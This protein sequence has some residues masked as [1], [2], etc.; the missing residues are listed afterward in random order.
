MK[1]ITYQ[2][3]LV[4][5]HGTAV[6]RASDGLVV[7]SVSTDT[8]T[9]TQGA[10]FVALQGDNFD[11]NLYGKTAAERGAACLL[12]SSVTDDVAALNIPVI[13][14][15]DT[16]LALQR[17]AMW[18]RKQLDVEVIGITGSNGKTS[19]KDF[20]ASVL[21]ERFKVNATKGN[22][23]NHIGLPLS[24]LSTEAD[25][26]V[27]VWEMG[28]NHAGEIAPL[29]EISAPNIGIIT[30]IGTAH[31]EHLGSREGIAEEKA[32]LARSLPEQGTLILPA[33]CDFVDY[34][35]ERTRA[36]VLIAG[37]CRG[38]VRAE[39]LQLGDDG[40][41]FDLCIDGESSQ[42]VTLGV[43]G[44]HMVNNALLAAASGHSLGMTAEEI[45]RGLNQTV[46][47]SGRL[48]RF[49]T[50]GITIFDDTY[51]ANPDSVAAAIEA[52]ADLPVHN[53]S[54]RVIVLGM[55]AELGSFADAEHLRIGKL[56]AEKNLQVISVGDKAAKIYQGAHEVSDSAKQFNDAQEAADWLKEYT[57]EGDCVLF[58]GS[59]MAAM[60][61]VMQAAF[62]QD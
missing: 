9:L 49:Q 43:T 57:Q 17:L 42:P 46:L 26:Q 23:N 16:L 19:T 62:P 50:Q 3:I 61:K 35:I 39:N 7:T 25:D 34:V 6:G 21:A 36:K 53:G 24:V 2:E 31:I 5:T 52:L 10:L 47:T 60:E 1:P 27:C 22:L 56:A 12:L 13:V 40:A 38:V 48:R 55:M 44:K 8:R 14:V 54:R 18:Y 28:M 51:N 41:S 33:S 58:K 30:N 59:R 20:T 4:A 29:C 15:D 37:N 45:A 11:G 32:A